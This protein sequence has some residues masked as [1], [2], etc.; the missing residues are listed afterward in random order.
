MKRS[1]LAVLVL[2]V[3]VALAGLVFTLQGL[4]YVGP[5]G[6]LMYNNSTWVTNGEITFVIGAVLAIAGIALGRQAQAPMPTKP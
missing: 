3:L 1:A 4:G 6:G 5:V 2:G